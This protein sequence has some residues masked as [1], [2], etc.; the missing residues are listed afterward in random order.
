MTPEELASHLKHFHEVMQTVASV[1]SDG[2]RPDALVRGPHRPR[3][4]R[5]QQAPRRMKPGQKHPL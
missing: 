3:G 1:L 5:C 2:T 4:R